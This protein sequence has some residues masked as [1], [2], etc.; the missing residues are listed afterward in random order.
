MPK[1]KYVTLVLSRD[2]YEMLSQMVDRYDLDMR[3]RI[4][5]DFVQE[6]LVMSQNL[7]TA[8]RADMKDYS[9]LARNCEGLQTAWNSLYITVMNVD[10]VEEDE[11]IDLEFEPIDDGDLRRP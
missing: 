6:V 4:I 1:S 11:E 7:H 2:E 3:K 9:D 5:N 10:P 8:S